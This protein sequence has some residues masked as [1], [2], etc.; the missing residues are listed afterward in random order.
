M[1][2]EVVTED[3]AATPVATAAQ[4]EESPLLTA[5]EG[6]DGTETTP[7]AATETEPESATETV[8]W[9]EHLA[10]VEDTDLLEH[11]KIKSLLARKEESLRQRIERD[12]QL[13]AGSNQQVQGTVT[14]LLQ[15]LDGGEISPQQFQQA[16]AQ[17]VQASHYFAS[18]EIGRKLPE[19]LMGNYKI[20]VEYRERAIEEREQDKGN[21]DRYVSTLIEGA[22]AAERGTTRLKDVPEGSALH[23]D[24]QSEVARRLAAELKAQGVEAQSRPENPPATPRGP[25]TGNRVMSLQEIEAMPTNEWLAK[26]KPERD[27]LLSA[28]RGR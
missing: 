17:A 20:P 7:V 8:S 24:V 11:P 16:A 15:M 22:V 25:G 9:T 23:K 13:Q 2:A 28:A 3:T 4:A 12:Q 18:V 5:P 19:V 27:R 1:V 10:K 14:R 21:L 6:A 26:P